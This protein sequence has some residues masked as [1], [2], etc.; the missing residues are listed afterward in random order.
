[1]KNK[2]HH[3]KMAV[4]IYILGKSHTSVIR[5]LA[6]NPKS[7]WRKFMNRAALKDLM[8]GGIEEMTQNPRLFYSSSIGVQYSHWTESGK[9]NL[10]EFMNYMAAEMAKCKQVE[11][12]ERSKQL[13][14]R[15]LKS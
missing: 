2:L 6:K 3:L 10:A 8:Y 1:M 7:F 4:I 14:L 5:Y 13:V 12:E 11:D 9:E 15:E